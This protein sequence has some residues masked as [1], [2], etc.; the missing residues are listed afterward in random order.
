LDCQTPPPSG[1]FKRRILN[2]SD[3]ETS[4]TLTSRFKSVNYTHERSQVIAS[5]ITKRSNAQK[6]AEKKKLSKSK[7]ITCIQATGKIV[8]KQELAAQNSYY[9][10]LYLWELKRGI[11]SAINYPP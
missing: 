9:L 6:F 4:Q 10:A 7:K 8:S 1:E 11:R 5:W 3:D 2:G